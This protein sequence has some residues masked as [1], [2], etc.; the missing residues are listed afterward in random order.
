MEAN[1]CLRAAKTYGL[2]VLKLARQHR[3]RP[4]MTWP[5]RRSRMRRSCAAAISS[6]WHVRRLEAAELVA[7][8]DD[9]GLAHL[10]GAQN[11]QEGRVVA[12]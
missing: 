1:G 6:R 3:S 2:G 12:V 9:D 7:P 8:V 11:L 5:R 4:S 10:D